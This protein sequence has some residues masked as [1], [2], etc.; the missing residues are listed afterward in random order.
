MKFTQLPLSEKLQTS[1][2]DAGF[3]ECTQ[4]QEQAIPLALKGHD[5]FVQSQTGTGKTAAFLLSLFEIMER[6]EYQ[7]QALIIVPTRELVT[8]V[9]KEAQV[10]S[11]HLNYDTISIYG[12]V[13]YEPQERALA[14]GTEIVVGTPGRLIDLANKGI[15]D[16]SKFHYAV[17]DEADR[18]FDM[19]FYQ[20]IRRI[21]RG[22]PP[23]TDRLTMLF[24][25]TLSFKVKQLASDFMQPPAE[26]T[27]NPE[28]V[29]VDAIEQQ[30]FHV[31]KLEKISLL[32]GLIKHYDVSR[33]LVF[34]NMK[35]MCEEISWRLGQNGI[36]AA[37]LT[38]D[39]AQKKREQIIEKFKDNK[40][41][42]LIATDVAA[43]GIH[44]DDLQLVINYDIP[45]DAEN[46]IHRIGRTARA[47]N[48]GTAITFAC[49]N[50]VE[51]LEPVE[52]L[53]GKSIPSGVA[54][55]ELYGDD[56]SAGKRWRRPAFSGSVR[57]SRSSKGGSHGHRHRRKGC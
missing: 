13:S 4:V 33:V 7:E 23:K 6:S 18:M 34:S 25:A 21:F 49:E 41:S 11:K 45:Q 22:L 40:L 55:D 29:T 53:L 20:D 26:I 48:S 52:K 8:Q 10:L 36:D 31:G 51:Y 1:L 50:Y 12:G 44:I 37:H 24:S 47:G 56:Q 32:L 17:I 43:R 16:L 57:D 2:A 5:I 9:E 46:Y 42:V 14:K 3:T 54:S 27:I 39:L 19:G 35:S 38:G 15:L 30:L 28:E